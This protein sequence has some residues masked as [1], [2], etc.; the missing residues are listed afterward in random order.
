MKSDKEIKELIAG[1]ESPI[2]KAKDVSMAMRR[3]VINSGIKGDKLSDAMSNVDDIDNL[4]YYTTHVQK[5][6]N[7]MNDNIVKWILKYSELKHNYNELM[8]KSIIHEQIS[9]TSMEEVVE[10]YYNKLKNV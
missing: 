9:E 6:L 7:E 10:E 1:F 5:E 8:S 2:R 4:I 3:K